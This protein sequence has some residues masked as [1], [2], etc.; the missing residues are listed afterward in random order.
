MEPENKEIIGEHY[1]DIER[2]L[3]TKGVKLP[4]FVVA[5]IEKILHVKQLNAGIYT[6]RDKEG[7]DFVHEFLEGTGPHCLATNTIV[8]G[9]EHMPATGNPIVAGNHPLGGPD[10][11]A[12]IG[13][14]GRYRKDI[15]FPVNDFLMYLPGLRSLFVP[16]DKVNRNTSTV[17]GLEAAFA[18]SN[19]LLYFPAGACSRRQKGEIKD[20][21]WKSTF[22]KKAVR[23]QRDIVPFYF[24][25]RNS[26][27]FYNIANLRKRLGIKFG[28]EMALLPGEMYAQRGNTFRLVIGTPIP[29][30][31]FDGRRPAR[32]WAAMLREHTYRLKDAPD[33]VFRAKS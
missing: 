33:A 10:G 3:A 7:L 8:I 15:I 9:A 20:L 31:T 17:A 24:D 32:E 26:N 5:L 13:A 12:L 23:Y 1:I 22:V 11:L 25:A 4:K 27:R 19:T 21:E 30:Q 2:I 18:G 16:I 29:W 28:F 6:L 14:V